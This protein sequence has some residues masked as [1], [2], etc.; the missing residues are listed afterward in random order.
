MFN[1]LNTFFKEPGIGGSKAFYKKE[2]IEISDSGDKVQVICFECQ[3]PSHYK[4][5]CL[6][7]PKEKPENHS[8]EENKKGLMATLDESDATSS[9]EDEEVAQLIVMASQPSSD[10]VSD[11]DDKMCHKEEFRHLS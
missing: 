10:T 11:F 5:K 1:E 3:K 9:N 8:S 6:T 2:S 4:S 7:L